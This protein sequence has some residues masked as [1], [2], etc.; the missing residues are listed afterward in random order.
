M[1]Y[2]S[3]WVSA[4][5]LNHRP[6]MEKTSFKEV[7]SIWR[8]G[9]EVYKYSNNGRRPSSL[10]GPNNGAKSRYRTKHKAL[11]LSRKKHFQKHRWAMVDWLTPHLPFTGWES[12]WIICHTPGISTNITG[13]KTA[14][15]F[16]L[17]NIVSRQRR[18]LRSRRHCGI[19]WEQE[20]RQTL[21]AVAM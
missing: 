18:D 20:S 3:E 14:A 7:M 6:N 19:E 8:K 12:V 4:S 16:T 11:I 13:K 2:C 9:H 15:V 10:C 17:H 1:P 21:W 5:G